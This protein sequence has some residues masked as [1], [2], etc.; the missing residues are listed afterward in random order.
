MKEF[1]KKYP[2]IY[3]CLR[4][5]TSGGYPKN[6]DLKD[7]F[8]LELQTIDAAKIFLY[9]ILYISLDIVI[10]LI[11]NGANNCIDIAKEFTSYQPWKYENSQNNINFNNHLLNIANNYL[12]DG[13]LRTS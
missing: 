12:S 11:N 1:S 6:S 7:K 4:N 13:V 9:K 10:Q 5:D 2:S 8:L 3:I